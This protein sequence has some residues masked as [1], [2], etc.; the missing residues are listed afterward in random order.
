MGA[1]AKFQRQTATFIVRVWV[2]YLQENPP[3]WRGEIVYLPTGEKVFF[4]DLTMFPRFVEMQLRP[5]TRATED[6]QL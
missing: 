3:C 2:E 1:T 4:Q 6:D 5:S